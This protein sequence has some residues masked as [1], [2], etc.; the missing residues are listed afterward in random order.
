MKASV[1]YA[2]RTGGILEVAPHPCQEPAAAQSAR[3][4]ATPAVPL[5]P[6]SKNPSNIREL[7]PRFGPRGG[8]LRVVW[9][10]SPVN[11]SEHLC[12]AQNLGSNFFKK[13]T[14]NGQ[15]S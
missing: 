8:S 4:R 6:V 9:I 13:K 2:T 15:F 10:R 14:I 5:P 1:A 12:H 7:H 11:T 3:Q